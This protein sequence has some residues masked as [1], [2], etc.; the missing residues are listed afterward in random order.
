MEPERTHGYNGVP[1]QCP[2]IPH[3]GLGV[4]SE[5][6]GVPYTVVLPVV[7]YGT[8]CMIYNIVFCV[9][10]VVVLMV[11]TC[12]QGR[13]GMNISTLRLATQDSNL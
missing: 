2:E 13:R 5:Y 10:V 9:C 4:L 7:G 12:S 6:S 11:L 1:K 8:L 3:D